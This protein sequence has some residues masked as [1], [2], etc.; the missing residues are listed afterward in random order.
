MQIRLKKYYLV[1]VICILA[2]AYFSFWHWKSLQIDYS[3]LEKLLIKKQWIEAD[4]ETSKI[5]KKLLYKATDDRTF[6][7]YSRIPYSNFYNVLHAKE[8]SK[9]LSCSHLQAI[10]EL[11]YKYSNGKFGFRIQQKIASSIPG[12]KDGSLSIVGK[13]FAKQVNWNLNFQNKPS[14]TNQDWYSPIQ[15]SKMPDGFLPSIKWVYGVRGKYIGIRTVIA[16]LQHFQN[17]SA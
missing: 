13:K 2:L 9:G 10:D 4:I 11:W 17:C 7:G 1:S 6:F 16:T 12:Y 15:N 8:R 3:N 14:L 5:M